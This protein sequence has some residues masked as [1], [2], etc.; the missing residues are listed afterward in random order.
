MQ[1][2]C[3]KIVAETNAI[4]M[5]TSSSKQS[6]PITLLQEICSR[7]GLTAEYQLLS[8]EGS[9]HEPTFKMA[10]TVD[11]I[12]VTAAGQSKKKAR[13]AAAKEAINKLRMRSDLS[14]DGIN[15]DTLSSL[16][17]PPSASLNPT[18]EPNPVGKL[19]EICMKLR[20][21]PPDY[22]TYQEEGLAHERIFRISC[23]INRLNQMTIGEGRSKKL[24]KRQAAELMLAKLESINVYDRHAEPSAANP[25]ACAIHLDHEDNSIFVRNRYR[26]DVVKKVLGNS[27]EELANNISLIETD[28]V[29]D[30]LFYQLIHDVWIQDDWA[31]SF[32]FEFVSDNHCLLHLMDEDRYPVVTSWGMGK[33]DI[34][35]MKE[36]TVRAHKI[37]IGYINPLHSLL[38]LK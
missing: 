16:S 17:P 34:M 5:E 25:I 12:T 13:H 36:A 7:N 32:E 9:V 6:P 18:S 11:N 2:Y 8:T 10:V 22:D 30:D 1:Q 37:L 21:N 26:A 33:N 4:P 38:N 15:F 20:V 24:A 27:T 19:Q 14:I 28:D 23:K 31:G 29:N 3:D 35:A